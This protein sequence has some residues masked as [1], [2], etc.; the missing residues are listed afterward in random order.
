MD[1]RPVV[2][3]WAVRGV[4]TIPNL[5]NLE[6][7]P[8]SKVITDP[9]ASQFTTVLRARI[10]RAN[11]WRKARGL[12]GTIETPGWVRGLKNAGLTRP[13]SM[14]VKTLK[15]AGWVAAPLTLIQGGVAWARIAKCGAS[16]R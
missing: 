2:G 1:Y 16:V 11:V 15:V 12:G 10:L 14:G 13:V 8:K 4:S 9:R 7:I 5:T 6:V 3:A